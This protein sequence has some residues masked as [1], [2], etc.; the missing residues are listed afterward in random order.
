MKPLRSTA[1]SAPLVTT[2]E[3]MGQ[4][5][6]KPPN[7]DPSWNAIRQVGTL[8]ARASVIAE[9]ITRVARGGQGDYI[10]AI[11]CPDG[12][13]SNVTTCQSGIDPAGSGLA[14]LATRR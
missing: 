4:T 9:D 5:L 14:L 1:R 6:L 8:E 12:L 7:D 11:A 2:E 10:N 3:P 13:H